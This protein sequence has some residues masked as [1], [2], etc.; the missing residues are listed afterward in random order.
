LLVGALLVGLIPAARYAGVAMV[1]AGGISVLLLTSGKSWARIKKALLFTAIASIPILLWLVWI[2]FSTSHSL[3]GRRLGLDLHELAAQF[4]SFRGIFMDTVWK[5]VPFQTHET[6]LGYRLRFVLMGL[7][8]VVLLGLSILAER[9]IQK[10]TA[11]D[12]RSTGMSIFVFFGLSSLSFVA[13]LVLTYLFTHPTIDVDNRMLLPLFAGFVMTFYAA[14]ALWQAA[15]FRGRLIAL[16]LLP[17]LIAAICVAWYIPQTRNEVQFYH[18]G[19]GL[20]AYRWNHS[21]I[22]QAVRSLPA[23]TPIISNDWELLQLW[24]GRAIYGF[25]NTFPSKPSIQS[26]PYG[27]DANDPIQSFFCGRGA[28]LVIINDFPA[29]YRTQIGNT[30]DPDKLFFGLVVYGQYADGKIYT[31][32]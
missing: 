6:L 28:V 13:V 24:T 2:Y 25:W 14:F 7:F 21:D 31:C 20:T 32:R 17:W 9:R 3:G 19:D 1:A 27:S 22:I 8:L 30:T 23:G 18:A 12:S 15:W 5:W 29:Q 11:Q 4:Q 16:R 10:K 26:G